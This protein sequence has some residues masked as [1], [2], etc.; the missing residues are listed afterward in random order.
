MEAEHVVEEADREVVVF[1]REVEAGDGALAG[2]PVLC[3]SD[4]ESLRVV[5]AGGRVEVEDLVGARVRLEV[6]GDEVEEREE[7]DVELELGARGVYGRQEDVVPPSLLLEGWLAPEGGPRTFCGPLEALGAS[8][9]VLVGSGVDGEMRRRIL[10]HDVGRA[11]PVGPPAN[12]G[13]EAP[14]VRVVGGRVLVVRAEGEED[15]V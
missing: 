6:P 15:D 1:R 11:P 5:L 10:S 13:E 2:I 7:S 12:P 8:H 4:L 14:Q 3:R 9:E